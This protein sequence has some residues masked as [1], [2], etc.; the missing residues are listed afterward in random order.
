MMEADVVILAIQHLLYH[1]GLAI[2]GRRCLT[3]NQDV[4][5]HLEFSGLIDE[6]SS[7]RRA[8]RDLLDG[9]T[10]RVMGLQ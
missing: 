4:F 2:D 9:F 3:D 5:F 10:T 6:S 1:H 7:A 8:A